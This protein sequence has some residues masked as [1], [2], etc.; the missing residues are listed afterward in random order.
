MLVERVFLK[1]KPRQFFFLFVVGLRTGW[2]R[3]RFFKDARWRA[4]NRSVGTHVRTKNTEISAV[5]CANI[6]K[7]DKN[8]FFISR[9]TKIVFVLVQ[10][11]L[12]EHQPDIRTVFTEIICDWSVSTFV[13]TLRR[14][15]RHPNGKQIAIVPSRYNFPH[16]PPRSR[17]TLISSKWRTLDIHRH[18]LCNKYVPMIIFD[19][20]FSAPIWTF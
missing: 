13:G 20:Q 1:C 18:K 11:H 14:H 19:D 9:I 16:I 5:V 12:A 3:Y 17:W 4:S 10:A 7:R 2:K 6:D 15:H 8:T